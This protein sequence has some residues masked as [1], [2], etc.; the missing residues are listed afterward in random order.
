[1]GIL[2]EIESV[3]SESSNIG[4]VQVESSINKDVKTVL[5][6]TPA[7]IDTI[8]EYLPVYDIL[9]AEIITS[10]DHEDLEL[11]RLEEIDELRE[12]LTVDGE[13][14]SPNRFVSAGKVTINKSSRKSKRKQKKKLAKKSRKKNR[15]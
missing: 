6:T 15:K 10:E 14:L 9:D 2:N 1:M 7:S 5:T 11:Q 3:I 8:G 4:Y 12:E 13:V